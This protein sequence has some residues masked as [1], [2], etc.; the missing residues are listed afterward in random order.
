[1]EIRNRCPINKVI[2]DRWCIT[3]NNYTEQDKERMETWIQGN[4]KYGIIG[5]EV[6]PTTGT[7]HMQI[8]VRTNKRCRGAFILATWEH[9]IHLELARGTESQNIKYCMKEGNYQEY[10]APLECTAKNMEKEKRHW[11]M[12]DVYMNV[13]YDQFVRSYPKEAIIYGE[14]LERVRTN[15]MRTQPPWNG[16]LQDKNFWIYGA[17]GTGKSRWARSQA[18]NR[19]DTIYLKGCN[20]WWSGFIRQSHHIVLFEDFPN[21]AKYLAQLMKVWSDRYTFTAETKGSSILINP[22]EWFLIVTSNYSIG[23]CFQGV[24]AIALKR[25]FREV[26]IKSNVD[27]FLDT[28][29]NYNILQEP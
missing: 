11:E 21:D 9:K 29:L 6:A 3:W 19:Q 18:G 10:G 15:L 16:E 22:G 23:E 12:L 28:E 24:D 7:R 20:K 5:E 8:Y 26:E 1:M 14:K 25:R 13:P 17:P 4:C 2:G 27:I